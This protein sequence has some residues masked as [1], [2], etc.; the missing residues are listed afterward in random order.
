MFVE[1]HTV[2]WGEMAK[3]ESDSGGL[4]R[5]QCK[6]GVQSVGMT[7]REAI[8][9]IGGRLC[10]AGVSDFD[11]EA[12]WI[13]ARGTGYT[14]SAVL[15]RLDDCLRLLQI[16]AIE[17]VVRGRCQRIPLQH[18]WGTGAFLDFEVEV[19]GSVLVPRPET[20]GLALRA[21]ACLS[22]STGEGVSILDIGTGSGCLAIA[23]ARQFPK[24]R[25]EAIDISA[26]ALEIAKRNA[27]LCSCPEIYFRQLDIFEADENT[28]SGFDLVVSNPPYIPSGDIQFLE[29]EVRDHDPRLALDGGEEGL[30]YYRHLSGAGLSW[31]KS[32][33]WMILEYGDRQVEMVSK[34]F[35]AKE[36]AV[37]IEKDLSGRDRLLIVSKF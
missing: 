11:A 21:I 7:F 16:E 22:G 8:E 10:D 35:S 13:V 36:L 20:E 6:V 26:A 30:K 17:R 2:D 23:M 1:S 34:M 25:V 3:R 33:G 14:R 27:L 5:Q 28:F 15:T 37:S 29:P 9:N 4:T 24:A 31:V 32:G 18:L 12:E 19:N